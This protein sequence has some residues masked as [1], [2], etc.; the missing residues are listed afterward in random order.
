VRTSTTADIS[1]PASE[2][3]R[4]IADLPGFGLLALV[5]GVGWWVAHLAVMTTH[6]F[7]GPADQRW[8]PPLAGRRRPRTTAGGVALEE[9]RWIPNQ[10]PVRSVRAGAGSGT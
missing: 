5:L 1:E 8:W 4:L 10:I 9:A 7:Y 3:E 6:L 2:L